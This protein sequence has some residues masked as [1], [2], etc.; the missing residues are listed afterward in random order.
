MALIDVSVP[1]RSGMVVWQGDSIRIERRLRIAAGDPVNLTDLELSVHT[2]THVDAP[3]HFVDG[4]PPVDAL[5][6]E[7]FVGPAQVVDARDAEARIGASL[8]EELVPRGAERVLFKTRSATLWDLDAFS[9]DYVCLDASG[10]EALAKRG[11]RLAGID[12]LTI[13][14]DEA[15]RVLFRAGIAALEG[16][17]LRAAE[18]GR[19][20][21][22]CTPVLIAGADGAPARALLEPL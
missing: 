3:L 7:V 5:P 21:L 22:L 8:V 6:P 4:A 20:R 13:G 9:E 2:G 1:L 19:Y 17:D 11:I 14:D 12:Y 10:A 16:L 15:H 18:P